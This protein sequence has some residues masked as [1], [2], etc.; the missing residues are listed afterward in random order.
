MRAALE[1]EHRVGAL[2]LDREHVLALAGL[3]RLDL[4]TATLGIACEHAVHIARPQSRLLASGAA[5]DLHDH[6]LLVVG[7]ALHHRQAELLFKLRAALARYHQLLAQLRTRRVV[8]RAP[9]L[10]RQLRRRLQLSVGA[11]HLRIALAVPDHL[12]VG[13]LLAE[14]RKAR[15]YLLDE[16][17]DHLRLSVC[18]RA[19]DP[20]RA[21][22]RPP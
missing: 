10:R 19:A 9:P 18:P 22:P 17:L 7:I 13:H 12:R 6:A 8:L 14:L 21:V 20:L 15:L 3:Q 4:P 5:L 16:L 11:A 1:L 2:A